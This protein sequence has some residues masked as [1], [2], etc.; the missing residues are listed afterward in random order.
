MDTPATPQPSALAL[1]LEDGALRRELGAPP[2]EPAQ[3]PQDAPAAHRCTLRFDGEG[4]EYFRIWVVNLLLTLVTLG[5]YSAWAKV[6]K[7]RWFAQHTL[8]LGDRFDFHGNPWRI[9]IGRLFA[10]GL[11]AL[12]TFAFDFSATLG[13]AVLAL[14]C[15]VGP[16]LFASAQRFRLANTSWRGLRFAFDAPRPLVYRVCVPLLLLWTAG[17][18]LQAFDVDGVWLAVAGLSVFFGFPLAHARL[19]QMQHDHA[20]FGRHRFTFHAHPKQFYKVYA[21][22]F[23]MLLIASLLGGFVAAALGGAVGGRRGMPMYVTTLIGAVAV[24]LTMWVLV[25][26]YFA[27][28]MQQVVWSNTRLGRIRFRGEMRGAK[29]WTLV[30]KQTLLTLLTLGLYWPFASVAIAR[31]RVESLAAL[32]PQPFGEQPFQAG[33]RTDSSALGDASADFFGLDI[34]W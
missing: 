28:R 13:L 7:A 2:P 3:P 15:V 20:R 22:A 6:R 31:Y 17:S 11:V 19:K 16:L 33:T 5:A 10:L 29:F 21:I 8:L 30:G 24:L 27:A 1:S 32:S 26:P 14:L 18:V 25:W 9:L 4:Q 34:G 23:L 12:W